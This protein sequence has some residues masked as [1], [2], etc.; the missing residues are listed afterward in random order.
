MSE[1]RRPEPLTF[2][3]GPDELVIRRRYEAASILN[4]IMI[5]LWFVVGSVM[6]FSTAWEVTGTWCFLLGSVQLLIRPAIRLSRQVHLRRV[7]GAGDTGDAD[8]RDTSFDY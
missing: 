2:R 6:F 4:D 3:I 7:Q 1:Q 5:A 8:R